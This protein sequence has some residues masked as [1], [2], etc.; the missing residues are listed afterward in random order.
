MRALGGTSG[1]RTK[2][3]KRNHRHTR[4]SAKPDNRTTD[5]KTYRT[6]D[7]LVRSPWSVVHRRY[8]RRDCFFS[9][10]LLG[11]GNIRCS[12]LVSN[13]AVGQSCAGRRLIWTLIFVDICP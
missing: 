3:R 12:A 6:T 8:P 4:E 5:D 10:L 1:P 11:P 2:V 7:S 9:T 13:T